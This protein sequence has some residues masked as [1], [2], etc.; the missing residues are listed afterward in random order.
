MNA[1]IQAEPS[2]LPK[3]K[4]HSD[5][6]ANGSII[7]S[8]ATCA[9]CGKARGWIYAGPTYCEA[10]LDKSLCPWCIADGTAHTKFGVEFVDPLA[11]GSYGEWIAP[12]QQVIEEICH[13]TP[14]FNGWQQERWFTHC[15]DGARFLG[16]A[17]KRE[18]ETLDPAASAAIRLES[19]Y[20]Q[21]EWDYY[22]SQMD[23]DTGPTAYIF[24]CE[25]CGAWGGYSDVH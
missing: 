1:F 11:V 10:E 14:C 12:P 17:G 23:I 2:E 22:L 24:R 20:N 19:G 8:D 4:Y 16:V 18:L 6:V 25:H 21:E 3:F 7:R 9:A 5:P 13:R 15:N